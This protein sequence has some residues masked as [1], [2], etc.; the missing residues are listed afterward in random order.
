MVSGYASLMSRGGF[1]RPGSAGEGLNG[2]APPA[3]QRAAAAG[4]GTRRWLWSC[5]RRRRRS[6]ALQFSRDGGI[7]RGLPFEAPS[8]AGQ[9][10]RERLVPA[11]IR[12]LKLLRLSGG[13]TKRRDGY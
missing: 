12:V 4:T 10:R 8:M 1:Q 9:L 3:R 7:W 13:V 6:W 5:G 11:E 2:P